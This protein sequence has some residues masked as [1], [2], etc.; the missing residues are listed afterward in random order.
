MTR[1]ATDT[2]HMIKGMA[3][4][5]ISD[6]LKEAEQKMAGA[7]DFA[8]QDF[9]AIRTG[10]AH[11]DMFN[12]LMAS[13]YGVPTPL[14]QLVTF[15]TPE[16]RTMLIT[17]FD[18]GA[19]NAVEKAIR[20]SDLGVAP[21]DDGHTIRVVLPEL[22]T[23]RRQEYT[24]TARAKAE[25]GRIAVRNMR[26]AR[27]DQVKKLEKDKEIG[28]D[29]ADRAEKQLDTVTKKYIEQIDTLLKAKETELMAV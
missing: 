2:H 27:I 16:P 5:T 29:D 22:T 11:P 6:I 28:E 10:R 25:E 13:Y 17:P 20:D 7:V 24:K 15:H 8:K 18:Q 12:K 19:L 14:Q 3:T 23:E 4:M 1:A 26:R 9:A 21:S